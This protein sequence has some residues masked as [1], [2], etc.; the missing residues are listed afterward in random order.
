MGEMGLSANGSYQSIG[1]SDYS[2]IPIHV[3]KVGFTHPGTKGS[4]GFIGI[5]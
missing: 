3:L 4:T 1:W 5:P 2:L